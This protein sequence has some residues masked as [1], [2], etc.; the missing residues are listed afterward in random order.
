MWPLLV[1]GAL[2]VAGLVMLLLRRR[3]RRAEEELYEQSYHE[4][5]YEEP[6]APAYHEPAA[7]AAPAMAAPMAHEHAAP[8]A[9]ANDAFPVAPAAGA[10]MAAAGVGMAAAVNG[11]TGRP[12]IELLM[13]PVRAGVGEDEAVVEFELSVDNHGSA[14]AEDVRVSTWMLAAGSPA[15]SEAERMLIEPSGE[16]TL[17]H[18]T[19]DA[20]EARQVEGAVAMPRAGLHDAVLPVVVAEARY[21]LPD[22]SEGRTSASFAVGVPLGEELAHFDVENPS[23]LHEHVVARLHGEPEKV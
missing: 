19:I 6:A 14:P 1:A 21:R 23:G 12:W 18:A 16:P 5:V 10:G 17:S 20:G 4:P 9:H 7:V 11:S 2:A 13:R 15:Q 8:M 3:R 22:G